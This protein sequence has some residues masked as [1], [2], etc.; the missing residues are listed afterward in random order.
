MPY[1]TP[2]PKDKPTEHDPRLCTICNKRID[3]FWATQ[4]EVDHPACEAPE[5]GTVYRN[6][7][8][9]LCKLCKICGMPC[10]PMADHDPEIICNRCDH[11]FGLS[12]VTVAR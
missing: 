8:A 6:Y 1:F 12:K 3:P 11:A 9:D 2:R 4:G 10:I 5:C 7:I